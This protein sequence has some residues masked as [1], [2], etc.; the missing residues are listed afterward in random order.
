MIVEERIYKIAAGRL[1]EYLE[2]YEALGLGLQQ[3]VLG[4]LIGYFTT[5]IGPLSTLVHLW[6]YQSLEDRNERRATLAREPAW[7]EYLKVCTPMIL[8]MENRILVPTS[9]SPLRSLPAAHQG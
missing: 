5:E 2:R 6:G 8:E 3:R 9:F 4:N 7:Q 1:P